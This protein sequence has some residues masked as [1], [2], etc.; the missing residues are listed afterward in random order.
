MADGALR[1]GRDDEVVGRA[2]F[3]AK[4]CAIA[5]LTRSTVSGSPSS[6]QPVPFCSARRKSSR[7]VSIPASAA[8]W[9]RRM[10]ASSASVFTRRRSSKN[11]PSTVSSTPLGAQPVGEPERKRLRDDGARDAERRD[12]AQRRSRARSRRRTCPRRSARRAPYSSLG[13]SSNRPSSAR[14]GISIEPIEMCLTPSFSRR[15]TGR[16]PERHLVPQLGRAKGVGVHEDV[17]HARGPYLDFHVGWM[18]ASR[19]DE[20]VIALGRRAAPPAPRRA[21]TSSTPTCTS[22]TTSTGWSATTTSS[23]S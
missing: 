8:R 15:G 9:A 23:S 1:A 11:S 10:P 18:P 7:A 6:T 17:W 21:P 13:C 3:A 20:L 22:G 12:R 14:R 19:A 4:V 16:G 2:P 5:S